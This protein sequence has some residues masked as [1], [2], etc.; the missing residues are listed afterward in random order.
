MKINQTHVVLVTCNKMIAEAVMN[1]CQKQKFPLVLVDLGMGET[2]QIPTGLRIS[3]TRLKEGDFLTVANA[4]N[5][6]A[7]QADSDFLLISDKT[8]NTLA[9]IHQLMVAASRVPKLAALYGDPDGVPGTRSIQWVPLFGT[10]YTSRAIKATGYFDGSIRDVSL[11]ASEW[12]T[13]AQRKG[14]VSVSTMIP[15]EL[16][17][18]DITPSTPKSA[19]L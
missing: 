12:A 5:I 2:P 19:N 6:G 3:F 11:A 9:S 18:N 7:I 1:T 14:W 10:Y 15:A 8:Y 13:R 17:S 16:I 4:A